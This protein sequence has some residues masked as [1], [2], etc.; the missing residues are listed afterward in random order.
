MGSEWII[1]QDEREKCQLGRGT[2]GGNLTARRTR[3]LAQL[4]YLTE[5][6]FPPMRGC[7]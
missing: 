1:L 5:V 2:A 6:I 7:G 3:D 4:R